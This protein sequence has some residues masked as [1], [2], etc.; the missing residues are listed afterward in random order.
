M[1]LQYI[2]KWP[3]LALVITTFISLGVSLYFLQIGISIVF[4]NLFYFPILIACTCYQRRGFIFSI[5]LSFIY[6]FLVIYYSHDPMVLLQALVRVFIFIL[7]AAVITILSQMNKEIQEQLQKK[8]A[9]FR[10]L[11]DT[12]PSGSAIYGVV[13]TGE[14]DADYRVEDINS[15]ALRYENR[16]KHEV[17]GRTLADVHTVIH[18]DYLIPRL[19]EA[20]KSNRPVLYQAEVNT[21]DGTPEYYDTSLFR[22]PTGEVVSIYTDV[23]EKRLMEEELKASE[24]KFR[25]AMEASSD[26]LWDWN[27]LTGVVYFSPAFANILEED[28]I[29]PVYESWESRL[30]PA[31]KERTLASLKEHISGKTSHWRVETRLKRSDGSWKWVMDR[32]SVVEWDDAGKPARMIG[33]IVD[34]SEQKRI[35]EVIR[36]E[37][38]RAEQYLNIAEVMIVAL[39]R[40]GTVV[41]INRKGAE[42]LGASSNDIIGVDWFDSYVPPDVRDSVRETFYALMDGADE[43]YSSSTNEIIT[44]EGKRFLISWVNTIIKTP[45]GQIIGTLSSG[46]DLT[47][48]KELEKEKTSLLDQIQRNLAQMAYL[49]D[50]IRNPLTIIMALSEIHLNVEAT[51]KIHEQIEIIDDS[52]NQLDKRWSESEKVLDFIR[53][54]YQITPK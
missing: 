4:Q 1:S 14:S 37:R 15:M 3:F 5:I 20:Q 7:I 17:I 52:I 18:D 29:E 48:R 39:S 32:G 25:L 24:E 9:L 26:G 44:H 40:D 35:E 53:K 30:H 28:H 19:V 54:H 16:Q 13:G 36:I 51:R 38:D 47:L 8:E 12:M 33:S 23:T 46:E 31:D 49:N 11:F 41:L 50:N 2:K 34:I 10:G 21:G 6:F 45:A 22:L 27:I 43:T 42:M